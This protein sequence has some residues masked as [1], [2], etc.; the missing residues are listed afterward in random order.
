MPLTGGPRV[1]GRPVCLLIV[2]DE[3]DNRELL[4]IIL[5][6]EGFVVLTAESG[7]EALATVTR[8][9]PHLVLLDV[10]MPDMDGFEVAA[11][12]K[13]ELATKDI[14]IILVTA[15]TDDNSRSLGKGCGAEDFVA[16][17]LDRDQLVMRVKKL[18]RDTY[19]DYRDN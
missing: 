10:M 1:A 4:D 3:R 15:M 5:S 7:P 19:R 6:W 2:D 11:T 8:E 14:P 17:P 18:L 16:K 13:R 12:I 9:L